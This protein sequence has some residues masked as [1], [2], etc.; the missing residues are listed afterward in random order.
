V[1]LEQ[2]LSEARKDIYSATSKALQRKL[3]TRLN[4][5]HCY[6][7]HM[8]MQGKDVSGSENQ[9]SRTTL[10][11]K[12]YLEKFSSGNRGTNSK[13]IPIY[14]LTTKGIVAHG[15]MLDQF[16]PSI[17]FLESVSMLLA[18]MSSSA[19]DNTTKNLL[20]ANVG[21]L[22]RNFGMTVEFIEKLIINKQLEKAV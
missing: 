16:M 9:S 3:S 5:S 18:K 12:G 19:R 21:H 11:A 8:V 2:L 15:E 22:T 4:T 10:L 20:I 1:T 7:I 13:L 17:P 14:R 6:V